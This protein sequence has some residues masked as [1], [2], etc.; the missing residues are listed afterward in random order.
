MRRIKTLKFRSSAYAK[1]QVETSHESASNPSYFSPH[2]HLELSRILLVICEF[3]W[4]RKEETSKPDITQ[5]FAI[6][7]FLEEKEARIVNENVSKM[8]IGMFFLCREKTLF[9]R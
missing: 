5:E 8:C 2:C 9:L 7:N 6:L 1:C 4:P 3:Y